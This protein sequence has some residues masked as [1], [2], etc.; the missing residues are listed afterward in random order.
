MQLVKQSGAWSDS[1]PGSK[2][3][4]HIENANAGGHWPKSG[5]Q[6]FAR[7]PNSAAAG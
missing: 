1:L 7:A 6:L 3:N 4:K 2:N 5:A